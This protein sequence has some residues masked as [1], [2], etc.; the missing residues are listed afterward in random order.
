M[1]KETTPA[2]STKRRRLGRNIAIGLSGL[3]VLGIASVGSAY[4]ATSTPDAIVVQYVNV[5]SGVASVTLRD[6]T[7]GES[8]CDTRLVNANSRIGEVSSGDRLTASAHG[9][10]NCQSAVR[11]A[12]NTTVSVTPDDGGTF[13]FSLR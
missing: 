11:F 5:P 3:S 1:Q 7:T 10:G 12:R 4:A 13:R 9:D 6:N 2:S 8:V